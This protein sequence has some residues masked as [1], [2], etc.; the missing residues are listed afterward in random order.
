MTQPITV[1]V[2]DND[3]GFADLTAERLE[4]EDDAIV[5]DVVTSPEE[6]LERFDRGA[7][8][9]I[10]SD[11]EMP[12]LTGLE[13]LE[14]VRERD[15]ELPVILFTGRGSEDV[16]SEAITAGVTQYFRKSVGGE[17]FALLANQITNAVSQYRTKATLRE[18][19]RRYERRVATLHAATREL[20]RAET[21][22]DIYR[23]TV[24]TAAE[25][26]ESTAVAAYAFDPTAGTLEHVVASSVRD[27]V[28][29][30]PA[31]ERGEGP[32]W[33]VFS[34][35]ESE[36][37]AGDRTLRSGGQSEWFV[38]VGAHGIVVAGCEDEG[39]FDEAVREWF[40]VLV[41][42]AEAA[43]DRAEREQLL[44]EHD[45]ALTQQNE[46]LTRL[47]YINEI[48]REI[49]HGIAQ[50]STRSAIETTV[51]E[52]LADSDRYRFAWIAANDVTVSG[53]QAWA[54]VDAAYVDR[55]RDDDL[56]PETALANRALERGQVQ[57]V[58]NVLEAD[59]WDRRRTE[60]LT[61]GY[62][63]VVAV[64]LSADDRQY[65]VLLVHVDG[66]D[67]IGESEREVFAELGET[68]GHAIRSVER[69]QAMLTESRVELELDCHD[70][71][72]L[73][74][75]LAERI[76]GSLTIEG[77]I[78]RGDETLAFV[79]V[80]ATADLETLSDDRAAIE[81]VS[82]VSEG[83]DERLFK[84][85][86]TSLPLLETATAHDVRLQSTTVD[87]TGTTFTF[88]IPQST[89][90]RSLVESIREEYPAT[91][92]LAKRQM[93]TTNTPRRLDTHLEK[94]LTAKQL[95]AL[96]AAHYSG[97]F[98]WP[99]ESTGETLATALDVSAP[100]YHY[101]LRAAERKL[102]TL[103][104]DGNLTV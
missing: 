103:V 78:D 75:R 59:G 90:P 31:F 66:I 13:L 29:P 51:C 48:V 83:E 73:F 65:G 80:P 26:L 64:P 95:E 85:T 74:N 38:P 61:Y 4:R 35:G 100:T 93:T 60:A 72:L 67:S 81:T 98:E 15:P 88:E 27:P 87:E 40:H 34:A 5:C 82:L 71:R 56:A 47:N 57:L 104:F 24:E 50:A 52:R 102:V 41:A 53:P 18:N 79:T 49:N 46:A 84:L 91:E 17:Q 89:D 2:V 92:L 21:K 99:R 9:C 86:I 45:R 10:V 97:F 6:A 58:E 32:I 62:Q 19:E 22:H 20:M 28:D 11:Y 70:E 42:N 101:H 25:I 68:I 63:T 16:A 23:R 33:E 69:T 14:R 8:D 54:G 3:P 44:R 76:D 1:L 36:N 77:L 30:K 96:Q 55:I 7:I 37:A 94:Q 39:G 12:Q 43:L